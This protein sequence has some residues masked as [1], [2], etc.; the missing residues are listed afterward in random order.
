MESLF[1]ITWEEMG[2]GVE[3]GLTNR[4]GKREKEKRRNSGNEVRYGQTKVNSGGVEKIW[5]LVFYEHRSSLTR[6]LSR[7]V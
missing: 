7:F 4:E 3:R 1:A 5:I 6:T 2:E